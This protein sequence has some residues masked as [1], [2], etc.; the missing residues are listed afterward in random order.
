M[1]IACSTRRRTA[2]PRLG[3]LPCCRDARAYPPPRLEAGS[4]P[5]CAAGRIFRGHPWEPARVAAG[6]GAAAAGG[7]AAGAGAAEGAAA[8]GAGWGLRLC[9][10]SGGCCLLWRRLCGV[11][12]LPRAVEADLIASV[13]LLWPSFNEVVGV[14]VLGELLGV[15]LVGYAERHRR[16]W[17]SGW[18]RPVL[19]ALPE[20]TGVAPEGHRPLH[21]YSCGD[22]EG[23]GLPVHWAGGD[24]FGLGYLPFGV[25]DA[26]GQVDYA[27]ATLGRVASNLVVPPPALGGLVHAGIGLL[28]V[29][30]LVPAS[31][32]SGRTLIS[33]GGWLMAVMISDRL[34]TVLS[35]S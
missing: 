28:P 4:T 35:L 30:V 10:R 32:A 5:W 6:G 25:P 16:V 22:L 2:A 24:L 7:G 12:L 17:A 1:F 31:L 20:I 19:G 29:D 14:P 26:E 23:W 18:R 21:G 3:P 27:V 11:W 33:S 34:L 15:D 9:R 8:A 13:G